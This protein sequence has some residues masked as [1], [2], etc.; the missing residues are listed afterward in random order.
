MATLPQAEEL[1]LQEAREL[2]TLWK[3]WGPY[4][5]ERQWGTVREDYSSNGNAWDYFSHDQARSR[6]YRWGED[7]LAGISDDQQLLCF[8]VAL[9]NGKD[10]IIKERLFGLT[11]SEGNH[12]EDVKEY[13]FYLDSTPTHSYMKYLYKYPQSAFPY[14][15]LV[16]TN[17]RRGRLELEYELLDTGVFDDDRYFD[18]FVEYAK[19][20]A[21]DLLIQ[22]TVCNRGPV[23]A[24]LHLMPTLWFRNTW[25]WSTSPTPKPSARQLNDQTVSALH[26]HLGERFLYSDRP[27]PWLFTENETNNERI[28]RTP[29]LS[30]YVKDAIDD[31]IVHG[32]KDAVNPRKTGTKA[33]AHYQLTVPAHGSEIVR[34]RLTPKQCAPADACGPEFEG[35]LKTRKL[36]ADE[37]YA[38]VI[39]PQ[40]SDDE[41]LVMR[42]ALAGMLWSKQFYY[43]P[44]NKWMGD[45]ILPPDCH[46]RL[47]VR[48]KEWFHLE[49]ADILSMPDKWEYPWFAAWDLAF[50]C[51]VLAR[52]DLDFAKDQLRLMTNQV[53]LHPN[54]QIPAYEW[55]FSDVNPPVHCK[56]IWQ[57]YLLEKSVRGEG[58]R[59]FLESQFHKLLMNFTWWVNRKDELGNNVF[60]GGFL[61]LDNIGVFDRSSPLPTGGSIE[62]ADGTSWMAMFCL[63]ML[64]IA[65]ELA[66]ENPVY[67]EL[68]CKFFEHFVYI[69]MAMDRVGIHHDELWDEQDGFFYDVLRLPHGDAMRL[70]VR[71]MVGLVPLFATAV[72]PHEV[73]DKL[74]TFRE[75]AG[76]FARQKTAV[77]T[78]INHP[79]DQGVS[80]RHLLAPFNEPKLRRILERMLDEA[81]FL[82]PYG[83][84]ALSRH[85]KDHPYIF[86]VDGNVH[87]VDYEPAES[88]TGLFGGNSNWRGPIW[89]PVNLLLIQSLRRLYSYYGDEFKVECPKG[90]GHRI[91]LWEVADEIARRLCKI[92]LREPATSSG[93]GGGRPLYGNCNKF[94]TDPHWRDL[95]LY[96]EYFHGDNGAGIGASH[97]T[98]WT[99]VVAWLIKSLAV[100]DQKEALEQ[101]FEAAALKI[102]RTY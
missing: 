92:F 97:Q 13:Y 2:V 29:N 85:H 75:R 93:Q 15:D 16:S 95:I 53:Y 73:F 94:Q 27:V 32:S 65:I 1:R 81:E 30:P 84:R 4:L 76:Y 89:I 70:K 41:R 98:G 77:M 67:E 9:W 60:E 18:V 63:D 42:Q 66:L 31:F 61:G 54:G 21:E 20:S 24:S 57:I 102:I 90:S 62:Q 51:I 96:Y 48:N 11:N 68:A 79:L 83:I 35:G 26:A 101:G 59:A 86:T 58:D 43:Y 52:V 23:A 6:A 99:G 37:F 19:Q 3:K 10:P 46:R 14:A 33:A 47:A 80:G 100:L 22:I 39:P 36:E 91:T 44:V 12:G 8:A 72:F 78:E 28:F 7:G 69:A 56:A 17:R 64:T 55:N 25:S 5:S 49:S 87:R 50:H 38:A 40:L 71:S 74:P 45:D 88:S 82:S 34:L